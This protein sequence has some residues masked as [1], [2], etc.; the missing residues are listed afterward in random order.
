VNPEYL[1]TQ[2]DMEGIF[3]V[4]LGNNNSKFEDFKNTK[5]IDFAYMDDSRDTYRVNVYSKM[6]RLAMA[7]RHIEKDA[8]NLEDLVLP[9]SINKVLT[10]KQGIFLIT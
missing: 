1:L 3:F 4:L 8:K 5:D 2:E 9:P 7:I 6:G 10:L